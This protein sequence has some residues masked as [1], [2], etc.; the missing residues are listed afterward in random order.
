MAST[1]YVLF[2]VCYCLLHGGCG[3]GSLGGG[4]WNNLDQDD[5]SGPHA[6]RMRSR[7]EQLNL[8]LV[9]PTDSTVKG[10]YSDISAANV[11]PIPT[12]PFFR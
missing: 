7:S 3:W 11:T 12:L 2:L 4:G 10:A 5:V 6:Q 1:R 9:S 8:T